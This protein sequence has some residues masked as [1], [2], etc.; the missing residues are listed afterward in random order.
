MNH[1]KI[2]MMIMMMKNQKL[3]NNNKIFKN[4]KKSTK[5]KKYK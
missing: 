5:I 4:N 3:F 2:Q 1:N